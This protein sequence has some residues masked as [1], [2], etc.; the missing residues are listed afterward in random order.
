MI[1]DV[2]CNRGELGDRL[3]ITAPSP[4]FNGS[5][6]PDGN[7]LATATMDETVTVWD[8]STGQSLKSVSAPGVK[9]SYA[10]DGPLVMDEFPFSADGGY[11]VITKPEQGL[12][13][14][15]TQRGTER[16]YPQPV[17]SSVRFLPRG[18]G[19][20][21]CR[22]IEL[23]RGDVTCGHDTLTKP[24]GHRE[25]ASLALSADGRMIA[26][27]GYEGTINLWDASSL[28][29]EA[30]LLGHVGVV[31]SLAWSPDGKILASRSDEGTVSL[32]DVGTGQELERL[33]DHDGIGLRLLFS[34]DGSIL[35]GYG[36]TG[37][38][39]KRSECRSVVVL[40][41]APRDEKP[42]H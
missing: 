8:A 7:T 6:S 39:D 16:Q 11:L 36:V 19:I 27:G 4:I 28:E 37:V 30:S 33:E 13:V 18:D 34:A 42:G 41:Q 29:R 31:T 12:L 2:D 38:S 24:T 32:W 1:V 23:V 26:T 21:F 17:N 20:V 3:R 40:W 14:W 5:L 22:G 10:T 25:I 15:D 9:F 35:A